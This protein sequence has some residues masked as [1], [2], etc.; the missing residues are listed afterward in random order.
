M[1][2]GEH[3]TF[4]LGCSIVVSAVLLAAQE[5][6]DPAPLRQ[7]AYLKASNPGMFAHFGEGGA[8][9][10]HSGSSVAISAD[11]NTIAVG[12]QHE[13]SGSRGINGD[14]DDDSAY[15]AGAVYVFTR[16]GNGWAQ[17]AYIKASNADASDQF[18]SVVALSADG[19]TLA[20]SAFLESS[21]TS[22]VNGN[23]NDNS[24]PQA[25]AVYIFTRTG[26][27]WTHQ[28]YLKASNPGRAG[29]GD[30]FGD[31]DQFGFSLAL[32]AD[33]NTL[34]V[35]ANAEDSN[36]TGANSNQQDDSFT[37]AGA[38]YM[39]TRS[40]SRWTQQAYLKA[41]VSTNTGLGDQF[42][43]AVSLSADGNT[44][45]VGVYDE[46]GSGRAVNAP[47]DRGRNGSGAV[48]IFTRRGATWTRDTYLKAWNAEGGDSW[49]SS[50]ALSADGN[51]LALG[52]LDEDCLCPG[53]HT[54]PKVGASDQKSDTSAGAAAVFV[55]SGT[56]WTQ[57][58]YIKP[59]NPTRG[60]WFGVRLA[61]SG[62]GNTLAVGAQNEDG[63]ARGINGPQND[64][65]TEA[66]AVYVFTRIGTTWTQLAYVKGANTEAFDEF[67]GAVA[68]NRDGRALVV[69][70]RGEDSRATGVNGNA[71]DNSVDEAG[72]VYVFTR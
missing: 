71:A 38:V 52:S 43:Y 36:A 67:G 27:T 14:Q 56:I 29:K 44:L 54:D 41:D 1:R 10:G 55:R 63:A 60:D 32:N 4:G 9:D 51:T 68:L 58:A 25:G 21:A 45:A 13:A 7:V 11:G 28:A 30:E 26:T 65:A 39:F 35:G 12:A 15:N 40:G 62:D 46:S 57:E 2:R 70:A 22:G 50:V 8:L 19:N 66:G 64:D 20:V 6:P 48:Y 33:G 31:G 72:A 23:Q 24:L 49:G 42:G 59:S 53:V 16:A 37:S 69:G 18:G 47:I 3:S 61:L 17:Q 34:A 5:A